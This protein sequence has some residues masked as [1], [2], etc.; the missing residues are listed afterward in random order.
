MSVIALLASTALLSA[1]VTAVVRTGI[2][3]FDLAPMANATGTLWARPHGALTAV[4]MVLLLPPPEMPPIPEL[5]P[6]LELPEPWE[7]PPHPVDIAL[8]STATTAMALL[9]TISLMN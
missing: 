4:V 2:G 8:A 3:L 7:P 1:P 5:P 6:P 9:R